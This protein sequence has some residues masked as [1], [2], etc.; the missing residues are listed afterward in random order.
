MAG[1]SVIIPA[2][3]EGEQ[4][5]RTMRAVGQS[6]EGWYTPEVL[7]VDDHSAD[8]TL[9][10]A[11]EGARQLREEGLSVE[12]VPAGKRCGVA[13]AK[14]IGQAHATTPVSVFLDAHSVPG[15]GALERVAAPLLEGSAAVVGP[16]FVALPET[17]SEEKLTGELEEISPDAF[18]L[19][20]VVK[21]VE[22]TN[23]GYGR[24]MRVENYA[25]HLEWMAY[26]VARQ[27]LVRVMIVPGGCAGVRT[28]HLG[29][30]VFDG[31]FDTGFSFPWGAEDVELS[32]RAWR[33]GYVVA[34]VPG[35]FVATEFRQS[36]QFGVAAASRM[37]NA[38]RLAAIYFSPD[39]FEQVVR[40]YVADEEL[41]WALGQML[42]H[43]DTLDRRRNLEDLGPPA[44]R[45]LLPVVEEFGGLNV[46]TG[47][48]RRLIEEEGILC[49]A[50]RP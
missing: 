12:V 44:L 4:L 24:G 15:R 10:V 23:A 42:Y 2:Y 25:M 40:H 35:A 39:V 6:L 3:N 34:S 18:D 49:S 43:S 20:A 47:R 27:D 17:T 33:L 28:D 26:R 45:N 31:L 48:D 41:G 16:T 38:L 11:T 32:L 7:V 50:A 14:N 30:N 37:F 8:E 19:P 5:P 29:P 46:V 9:D 21:T 1:F 36:F 13:G 22:D